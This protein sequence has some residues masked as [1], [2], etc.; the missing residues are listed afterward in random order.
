MR[1]HSAAAEEKSLK[2]VEDFVAEI[3]HALKSLEGKKPQGLVD[4]Y[5]LWSC[6]HLHRAVEGFAILRRSAHIDSSKFLIRP[7]LEI[8][9]RLEAVRKHPDLL[10]RI[11]FSEHRQD[12]HLLRVAA[13]QSVE[14]SKQPYDDAQSKEKW[15]R[16]NDAFAA[17]FPDVPKVEETLSIECAAEKAGMKYIYDGHYRIYCRY[18]HGAL[19]ASTGDL[20]EA[21]DPEDNRAMA[22]CAMIALNAL[23]SLGGG[24]PNRDDLLQRQP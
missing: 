5:R 23:V 10:Y 16:F 8:A 2:L 15:K 4:N 3:T 11:A 22:G 7:A 9:F 18:T 14:Q 12:E 6:K 1:E 20:D 24:S 19:L 13:E 17:E 21:T